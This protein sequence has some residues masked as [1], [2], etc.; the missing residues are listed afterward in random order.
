MTFKDHFSGHAANYAKFRPTY[1]ADLFAFLAEAVPA[2][3]LAWDCATGN[4]QAARA[5][6]QHFDKV[7]ATDGSEQQIQNAVPHAKVTY[8]VRTAEAPGFEDHSFDLVTVAQAAHWLD[9]DRFYAQCRCLLKPNGMVA[10][11]VYDL[12]RISP[13]IDVIVNSYY[14]DIVGPYWPPERRRLE[15]VHA[16]PFPFKRIKTPAFD[17]H[18]SWNLAELVGYLATW[19][20]TQRYIK[21]RGHNPLPDIE[22]RLSGVW[23]DRENRRPV[24]WP[25]KI[26]VGTI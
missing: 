23:P 13:E 2:R 12:L 15:N 20:A 1:P 4:G 11:W 26:K 7:V 3:Q 17:M 21:K 24:V 16:L 18:T 14:E 10:M 8:L 19:S 9:L 22:T 25:L 6:A 5:L